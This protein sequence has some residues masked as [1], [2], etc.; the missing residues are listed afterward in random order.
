MK[1][2]KNYIN[3]SLSGYSQNFKSIYDPSKGEEIGKVILSN[4]KDFEELL[5]SSIN[6]QRAWGLQTPLKRSRILTNY[7][8]LCI[9]TGITI[10]HNWS[11]RILVV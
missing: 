6:S 9:L 10:N 11:P 3:G 5:K 2:I 8:T 7:K 1:L 4:E